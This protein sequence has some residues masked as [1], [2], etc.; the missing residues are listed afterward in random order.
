MLKYYFV[1]YKTY[2]NGF[3]IPQHRFHSY[4]RVILNEKEAI[5]KGIEITWENVDKFCQ[6]F[7][8]EIEFYLSRTEKGR[9]IKYTDFNVFKPHTY[10]DIEGKDKKLCLRFE[11]NFEERT[12]S[13]NDLMSYYDSDKV[14][15]YLKER[16]ITTC[17]IS[18]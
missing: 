12:P 15:Q 10:P 9:K 16:G 11:I 3:Q 7:G 18:V 5:N 4:S 8:H 14:I 6:E 1:S 13:M 17:P 2:R